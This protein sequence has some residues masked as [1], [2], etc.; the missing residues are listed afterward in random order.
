MKELLTEWRKFLNENYVDPRIQKQL[1]ALIDGDYAIRIDLMRSD[2]VRFKIVSQESP[3]KSQ[4]RLGRIIIARSEQGDGKCLDAWSIYG[5][6]AK[7]NKGL[8]PLLY[9]IAL[10]WASQN[11]GGL[12]ADRSAVSDE[13]LA[14]WDKYYRT[15]PEIKAKQL[16]VD[17]D[18]TDPHYD[19][20]EEYGNIEVA[21]L[22]QLTPDEP[23]DDCEQ[24]SAVDDR[25]DYWDK[26]PLSKMYFKDNTE[27]MDTLEREGRLI[28]K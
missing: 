20:E 24:T 4:S 2:T 23:E 22:Q 13:A 7:Q 12:M 27:I 21:D 9:E 11:G 6:Q 19:S 26:S 1:D 25:G 15:R 16:D 28:K 14:V 8:G 5:S 18:R 3:D 17:L 10:E